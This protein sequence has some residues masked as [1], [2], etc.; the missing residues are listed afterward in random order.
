MHSRIQ[1]L[2]LLF[3]LIS[4]KNT[5]KISNINKIIRKTRIKEE[6][7]GFHTDVIMATIMDDDNNYVT[8]ETISYESGI[9]KEVY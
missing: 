5:E 6:V 4:E 3:I 9:C 7:E 2:L 1:S 8:S